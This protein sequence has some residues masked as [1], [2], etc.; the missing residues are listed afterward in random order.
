MTELGFTVLGACADRYAAVPTLVLRLRITERSGAK[1]DAI[2]LRTQLQ[3]E[4]QRRRYAPDE[5][6]LLAELFG[7]PSRY[8]DTLKPMLWTHVA[9]VVTAFENETEIDVPVACSYDFEIAAHK[10]LASLQDGI[11][12]L[13][14]L[15]S[16]MVFVEGLGGVR[17][18]FVPWS[19]ETRYALPLEVW[20]ASVDALFPNAA[21]IRVNRELFD[22]LRRFKIASGLP[23]WEGALERLVDLAKSKP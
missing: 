4:V 5:S 19:C 2:V 10:Y 15:F 14:L 9:Q 21:W 6:E 7:P 16:G 13:N 17:P 18:E 12:P 23:T 20:R 3:L 1:V 22:E 11:I 8:A